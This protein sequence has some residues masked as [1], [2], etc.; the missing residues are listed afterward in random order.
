MAF[1]WLGVT[2]SSCLTGPTESPPPRSAAGCG[3]LSRETSTCSVSVASDLGDPRKVAACHLLERKASSQ[4]RGGI[5]PDQ[6]LGKRAYRPL[7]DARCGTLE[8]QPQVLGEGHGLDDC[9]TWTAGEH[10]AALGSVGPQERSLALLAASDLFIDI[11]VKVGHGD[12]P[13]LIDV[14][15][16]G[17]QAPDHRGGETEVAPSPTA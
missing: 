17:L 15:L 5:V 11:R 13:V 16:T 12:E 4:R 9:P 14:C 10:E 8:R 6:D 2:L 7:P 1:S 3:L